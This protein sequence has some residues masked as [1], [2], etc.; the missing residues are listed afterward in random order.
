[1]GN[2][3]ALISSLFTPGNHNLEVIIEVISSK[4]PTLIERLFKSLISFPYSTHSFIRLHKIV[5][6]CS[7][8]NM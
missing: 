2:S 1:M 3:F 6:K 7:I 5:P 8:K 4:T